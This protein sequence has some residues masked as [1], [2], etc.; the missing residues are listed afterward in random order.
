MNGFKLISAN[1]EKRWALLVK[2]KDGSFWA[3]KSCWGELNGDYPEIPT[4]RTRE[5]AKQARKQ[6]VNYKHSSVPTR[7]HVT[8]SVI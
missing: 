1:V 2:T 7:V 6:M 5:L 4:F 3:G 8:V